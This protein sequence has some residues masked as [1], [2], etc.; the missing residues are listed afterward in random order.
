MKELLLVIAAAAALA[1]WTYNAR[2]EHHGGIAGGLPDVVV[3]P[4]VMASP[5]D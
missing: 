4:D 2:P 3:W 5:K 1:F